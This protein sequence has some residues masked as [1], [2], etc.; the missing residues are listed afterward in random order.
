MKAF[1][2]LCHSEL[3]SLSPS[4]DA[5][6]QKLQRTY[7]SSLMMLSA[8][9]GMQNATIKHL[10]RMSSIEG[11][12]SID[13][14]AEQSVKDAAM[15]ALQHRQRECERIEP[16]DALRGPAHVAKKLIRNCQERRSTPE[17]QYKLT[18]AKD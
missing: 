13:D 3:H 1:D 2:E 5:N 7:S 6:L 17:R 14:I 16:A 12:S 8:A 4:N 15:H 18:P 10:K 11:G 9:L